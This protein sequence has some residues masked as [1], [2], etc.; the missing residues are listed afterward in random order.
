MQCKTIQYNAVQWNA[1]TT[2]STA[3]W[4]KKK[5]QIDLFQEL[6]FY[7][8]VRWP[9]GFCHVSSHWPNLSILTIYFSLP[10]RFW[11]LRYK[12]VNCV[13]TM[14]RYQM[15]VD[16]GMLNTAENYLSNVLSINNK[17]IEADGQHH[18]KLSSAW[19]KQN[20]NKA[21]QLQYKS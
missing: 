2:F 18:C 1:N 14:H 6:N 5:T 13:L 12:H 8:L 17:L 19:N 7:V 21:A 20:T 11:S 4:S 9:N 3:S 10:F 15:K 16:V